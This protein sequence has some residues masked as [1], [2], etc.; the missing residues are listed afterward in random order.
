MPIQ[1]DKTSVKLNET[2][3]IS[4]CISA[5]TNFWMGVFRPD[6]SL[7]KSTTYLNRSCADQI[8]LTIT[9]DMPSG[10]WGVELRTP[11]ENGITLDSKTFTVSGTGIKIDEKPPV[12]SGGTNKQL[13]IG[14][15]IV[16]VIYYM[17]KR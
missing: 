4:A 8:P 7:Y 10:I 9:N 15:I 17:F 1:L 14:V 2:I 6:K 13:I 11:T 3:T 16:I 12:V 5:Q